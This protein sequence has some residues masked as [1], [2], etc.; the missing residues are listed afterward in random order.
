MNNRFIPSATDME[1]FGG[2]L[3]HVC[4]IQCV[5]HLCGDLGTGKTTLV[6]GFLHTLGYQGTVK[7]PTYTLV[8]PYAIAQRHIYHFDLYRVVHPDELEYLA[9][10][11]YITE[12]SVCLIE[13][14]ERGE[15]LTPAADIDFYLHHQ[16]TG[17]LVEWHA[18]SEKGKQ[19][20]TLLQS[21]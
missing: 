8:E 20:A 16:K 18:N 10:R 21:V 3:A 17:R 13:W 12:Q 9:I 5:I 15:A 11:D 6:R 19:I 14:P 1:I 7:S 4:P 2:H